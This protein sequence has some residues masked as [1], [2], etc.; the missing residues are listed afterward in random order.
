MVVAK[1]VGPVKPSAMSSDDV[2]LPKQVTTTEKNITQLMETILRVST[3]R[4]CAM[5]ISVEN[6]KKKNV[7]KQ[8]VFKVQW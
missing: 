4:R 1:K 5:P 8:N 2:L 6:L 7:K 3:R